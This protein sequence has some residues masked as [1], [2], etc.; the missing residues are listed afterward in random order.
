MT[1]LSVFQTRGKE[2]NCRERNVFFSWT[3]C[4]VVEYFFKST[5]NERETRVFFIDTN[6][7]FRFVVLLEVTM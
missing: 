2:Y 7:H 6:D 4:N 3:E 1:L 5:R